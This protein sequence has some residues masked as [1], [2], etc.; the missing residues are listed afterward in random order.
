MADSSLLRRFLGAGLNPAAV[1]LASKWVC[2]R[3]RSLSLRLAGMLGRVHLKDSPIALN[4]QRRQVPAIDAIPA[5]V[6]LAGL[7][8]VACLADLRDKLA[9]APRYTLIL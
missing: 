8:D 4:R 7:R 3:A 9:L 2:R 6:L 5:H 1:P